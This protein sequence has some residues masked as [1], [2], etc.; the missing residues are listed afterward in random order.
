M[1]IESEDFN[2]DGM[3]EHRAQVLCR[4]HWAYENI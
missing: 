1:S 2:E 3:V 4:V